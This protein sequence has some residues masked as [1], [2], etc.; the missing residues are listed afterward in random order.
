MSR[1]K[2][3]YCMMGR[4]GN[5]LLIGDQILEFKGISAFAYG[6]THLLIAY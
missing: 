1:Y 4:G 2:D 6:P 3:I 5:G